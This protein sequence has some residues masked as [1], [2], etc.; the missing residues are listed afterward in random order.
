MTDRKNYDLHNIFFTD[1]VSII[2]P[3]QLKAIQILY[4]ILQKI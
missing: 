1:S 2:V 3:M 4:K